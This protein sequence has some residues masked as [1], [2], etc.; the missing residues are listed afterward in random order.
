MN[1]SDFKLEDYLVE[2]MTGVDKS[3]VE[4]LAKLLKITPHLVIE[5]AL[6]EW[7][8]TNFMRIISL[9]RNAQEIHNQLNPKSNGTE[10]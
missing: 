7:L 3:M 10:T 4:S 1:K 9:H 5:T 6:H 8:E 2:P